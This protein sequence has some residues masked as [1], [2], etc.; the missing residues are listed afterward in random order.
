MY[1]A[2]KDAHL[3]ELMDHAIAVI[4][5]AQRADGYIYTKEIILQKENGEA[6]LFDNRLSFEAYNFGHLMT[7]ACV[8]YRA[9][10]KTSLLNVAKKAADFLIGFYASATP[11]QSRNAICPSHYMGL[12]EL[13][14]TTHDAR[15]LNLVKHL[16]AIKGAT[17]GTDDNQDRIPFLEQTKVMG[18]AVRAN[19]LYAGV[20]DVYAETGDAALL[21]QLNRMW[22]D[23]TQH[24]MY[25]TGGCGSLYDGVSPDGTSYKTRRGTENPSGLR[26]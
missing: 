22:D 20:A 7:A 16:V 18:H 23:L 11:E 26:P 3:D 5:K 21:S 10:G 19:Y 15:Y 6:R 1:A 24:K 25:V 12:S 4:A 13:Y 9:T 17:E 14:R 8:H 2:T